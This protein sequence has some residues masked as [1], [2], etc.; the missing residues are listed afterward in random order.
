MKYQFETLLEKEKIPENELSASL[1]KKADD[2]RQVQKGIQEA[3]DKVKE[4]NLSVKKKADL[5]QLISDSEAAL[6]GM[7]AS[8]VKAIEKWIPK[9]ELYAENAK[10]LKNGGKVATQPQHTDT[11]TAP[12]APATPTAA[13][14]GTKTP[15]KQ[16]AAT[17]AVQ[18]GKA[19]ISAWGWVGII[20]GAL[21]LGGVGYYGVVRMRKAA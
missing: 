19:K 9:R 10:R 21:L 20:A 16:A 17:P 11:S 12:A 15:A 13:G 5:E 14:T 6:P 7:D 18:E 2:I 8:L 1:R 4:G 3:K